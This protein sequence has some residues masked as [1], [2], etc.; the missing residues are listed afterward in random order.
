MPSIKQMIASRQNIKKAQT[1]WKSM[2]HRQHA[3][4]QPEGRARAKPGTQG[5]GEYFRVVLR[6]KD[7]FTTFRYHD[8]GRTG[9]IQRLAGKRTSGS[10]STQAWL[11][12]KT[13]AHRQGNQLVPDSESAQALLEKLGSKPIY[14]KG[15]IFEAKDRPNIPEREKPTAAM[16]RAQKENIKKA[17]AAVRRKSRE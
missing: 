4:A 11:I 16:R 9:H 13:D 6:P 14:V 10:W 12:S 15:D 17:Q 1:R 3:L 7:E 2:S 5:G 8:T